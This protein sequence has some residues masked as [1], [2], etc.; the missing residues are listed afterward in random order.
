MTEYTK[1]H[2]VDKFGRIKQKPNVNG[3]HW[4]KSVPSW[5]QEEIR[6]RFSNL[7]SYTQNVYWYRKQ[8]T[9]QKVY[10]VEIIV[11]GKLYDNSLQVVEPESVGKFVN[12][13][14]TMP[15]SHHGEHTAQ[16]S[17]R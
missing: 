7:S 10:A 6:E 11:D 15:S 4:T 5:F 17:P 1:T 16:V 13:M 3:I 14:Q 9:G 8:S 12:S 2:Y